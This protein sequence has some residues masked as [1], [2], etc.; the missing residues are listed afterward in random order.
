MRW[1]GISALRRLYDRCA[2]QWAWLRRL[3]APPPF[4]GYRPTPRRLAN[5]WL[6]RVEQ[7]WTRTRLWS[8]PY[9]LIIEPINACNLRCPGCFTG[10]GG[11]GRS[12]SAMPLALYDALLRELGGSLFEVEAFN[13]GEPLLS[14]HIYDMIASATARGI[15]TKV[16]TNFS[17]PFDAPRAERLVRSGLTTL[18]VSIDGARQATYERYRVRGD[19]Q[20]VLANCRLVAAAKRRLGSP[21][22]A[23]N[24]EFH[25]FPHNVDDY[26]AVGAL[27]AE[28]GMNLLVFK[29]AVPGD[30]WDAHGEWKFCVDP[31]PMPCVSLWAVA[32]VNNDGGVAPCNGTFYREDD[33]GTLGLRPEDVA[34]N[35]FAAVWNGPR[36]RTA[37]GFYARRDGTP[38]ERAHVCFDCPQTRGHEDWTRHIAAGGAPGTFKLGYTTNDAWNYFWNRRP[39]RP[40]GHAPG[41]I[42]PD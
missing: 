40:G 35:G 18:T 4:A 2:G 11:R 15:A 14:P 37:R 22:P 42:R 28:L 12:H 9:K 6:N 7:H 41:G 23:L 32:V 31:Q 26:R 5:L 1:F 13:W 36:F 25:V 24:W 16:N 10:A 8:Q 3:F 38:A 20:T 27:A 39:P 34:A 30:D 19:L 21:T 33:M 29:G 17:L